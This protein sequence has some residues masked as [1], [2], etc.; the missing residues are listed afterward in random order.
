MK[1]ILQYRYEEIDLKDINIPEYIPP[2]DVGIQEMDQLTQSIEKNSLISP[3]IVNELDDDR[4][5]LIG[6]QRRMTAL[7]RLG[8]TKA[9]CKIYNVDRDIARIMSM[10]DNIHRKDYGPKELANLYNQLV[11]ACDGSID[12]AA[13]LISKQPAELRRV[14]HTLSLSDNIL[15]QTKGILDKRTRDTVEQLLPILSKDERKRAAI[16]IIKERN[17]D[18]IDA[19][20]IIRAIRE[21]PHEEPRVAVDRE[22]D[23]PELVGIQLKLT[24]NVNAALAHSATQKREPKHILAAKFVEKCLREEGFL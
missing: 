1:T 7:G 16:E 19:K 3:L 24:V 17:A 10:A 4:I 8:R 2:R 13:K 20:K 21:N 14:L 23:V 6:G 12:Q 18:E 22:F 5:E 11:I 15:E 9:S